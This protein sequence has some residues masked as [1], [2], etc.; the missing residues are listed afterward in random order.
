MK[1]K[2]LLVTVHENEVSGNDC[3]DIMYVSLTPHEYMVMFNAL[4][5]NNKVK[6]FDLT[7]ADFFKTLSASEAL[8]HIVGV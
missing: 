3:L 8:N 5:G 1:K 6:L 4:S 7:N 2:Y